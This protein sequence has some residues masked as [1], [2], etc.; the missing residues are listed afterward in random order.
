MNASVK[1][2]PNILLVS[3]SAISAALAAFLIRGI[4]AGRGSD[5]ASGMGMILFFLAVLVIG[6]LTGTVSLV[7]AF[8]YLSRTDRNL[9][10]AFLM[11][12]VTVLGLG[13]VVAVLMV[14]QSTYHIW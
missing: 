7:K 2:V 11:F 4:G 14:M 13:S 5:A 8:G 9:L 6:L 10:A 3:G 12:V 1:S